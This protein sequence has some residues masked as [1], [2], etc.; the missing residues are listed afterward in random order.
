M[1][2]APSE[3][4]IYEGRPMILRSI[5]CQ[6]Y[7]YVSCEYGLFN[8]GMLVKLKLIKQQKKSGKKIILESRDV[9]IVAET[10]KFKSS[11][12]IMHMHIVKKGSC[13]R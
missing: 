5:S 6:R 1:R 13:A 12:E 9:Q 3:E 2:H 11:W 8:I 10:T 7:K 4:N